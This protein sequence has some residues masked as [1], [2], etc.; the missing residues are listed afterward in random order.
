M[1]TLTTG[2]IQDIPPLLPEVITVFYVNTET[3]Q[4]LIASAW[5]LCWMT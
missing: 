3:Y 1:Y 4:P 2:Q 5:G